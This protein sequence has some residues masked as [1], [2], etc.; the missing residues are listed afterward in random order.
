MY[1]CVDVCISADKDVARISFRLSQPT[2][3][4]IF[5]F[6]TVADLGFWAGETVI[7]KNQFLRLV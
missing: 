5:L 4:S 2:I 1:E 6:I 7:D 3:L